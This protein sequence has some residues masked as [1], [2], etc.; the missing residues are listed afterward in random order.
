MSTHAERSVS[1]VIYAKKGG[2]L[3]SFYASVLGLRIEREDDGSTM[4]GSHDVELAIVQAPAAIADTIRI[5]TPA[6]VRSNTPIKVSFL[7]ADIE[8]LRTAI[9]RS[10]GSLKPRGATWTWNGALHLDGCDPE[11]NVFQLR[12]PSP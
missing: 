8:T 5:A 9:E 11:G 1:I 7:V 10:G 4:L 2:V 12:Q 3:A 6:E